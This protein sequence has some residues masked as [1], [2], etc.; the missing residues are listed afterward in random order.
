MG[1][2][3]PVERQERHLPRS[4]TP[5][6]DPPLQPLQIQPRTQIR[7]QHHDHQTLKHNCNDPQAQRAAGAVNGV[8]AAELARLE[9]QVQHLAGLNGVAADKFSDLA[10]YTGSM[11]VF[12]DVRY[13]HLFFSTFCLS[14][15][16]RMW[17][18]INTWTVMCVFTI[19]LCEGM[20][21]VE[22]VL[23]N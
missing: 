6:C 11:G 16:V 13:V 4:Y 17:V 15:T 2:K 5:L 9:A 19:A 21:C 23:L 20:L 14:S 8:S 12:L 7:P 3:R 1:R 10:E 18:N 22:S